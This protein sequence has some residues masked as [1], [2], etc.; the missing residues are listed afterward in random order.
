MWHGRRELIHALT[1]LRTTADPEAKEV[2]DIALRGSIP[3]LDGALHHWLKKILPPRHPKPKS[4]GPTGNGHR[5][6]PRPPPAL[7]K[8]QIRAANF[9]K[10]KDLFLTQKSVITK[11]LI[12]GEPLSSEDTLPSLKDVEHF[13]G[14]VYEE[15][16]P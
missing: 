11:K 5:P 1:R 13:F 15:P 9:K 2:I 16:S 8:K 6:P 12:D 4:K 3:D 7:S 14:G 10:C